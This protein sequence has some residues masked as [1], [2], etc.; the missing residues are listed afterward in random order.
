MNKVYKTNITKGF[1]FQWQKSKACMEF[2]SNALDQGNYDIDTQ[3]SSGKLVVTNYDVKLDHKSLMLGL[4]SKRGDDSKR[5]VFGCGLSQAIAALI[6]QDC[7]VTLYNA[8]VV[9]ECSFELCNGWGYEVLTFKE[10]PN[11]ELSPNLKVV[12]T[13]LHEDDVLEIEKRCLVLQ[14]REVLFSTKYGD[15]IA[16]GEDN[17]EIFCG[18]MYVCENRAFNYSYNFAPKVLP[19]NQ[20]RNSASQWEI[21]RLTAKIWKQCPDKELLVE[22]IKSKKADCE[23]VMDSWYTS[24]S[25]DLSVSEDFGED[26]VEQYKN[27]IV[28]SN[29]DEYEQLTKCGNKVKYLDNSNQVKAIKESRVY[30]EMVASLEIIEVESTRTKLER[31]YLAFQQLIADHDHEDDQYE[32]FTMQEHIDTL[33]EIIYEL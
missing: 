32:G 8:D 19:L 27:H 28:T 20:D 7:K 13:G 16:H 2:V 31:I 10:Y 12:V 26:Y 6:D 33:D 1:C 29:F 15:V 23:Y 14:D 5:G 4:S 9:W 11:Q 30:T 24:D 18:D 25:S 22:A 3:T 17:G 21:S